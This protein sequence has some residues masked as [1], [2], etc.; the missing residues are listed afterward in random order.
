[1]MSRKTVMITL[2]IISTSFFAMGCF[3]SGDKSG[4]GFTQSGTQEAIVANTTI[5]GYLTDFEVAA[6]PKQTVSKAAATSGRRITIVADNK[7]YILATDTNGFFKADIE[8]SNSKTLIFKMQKSDASYIASE[9][10]VEKGNIYYLNVVLE[11]SGLKLTKETIAVFQKAM[12]SDPLK[13]L[14]GQVI[15]E[16]QKNK[17]YLSKISGRF[18]SARTPLTPASISSQS[19][20]VSTT[21]QPSAPISGAIVSLNGS[22]ST[23]TDENGYFSFTGQFAAGSYAV[24][25][26]KSGY[27]NKSLNINV[28]EK[29]YGLGSLDFLLQ[30]A[31]IFNSISLD[32]TSDIIVSGGSYELSK[33]KIY[34]NYLDGTSAEVSASW[35]ADHGTIFE[36]SYRSTINEKGTVTLTASYTEANTTRTAIFILSINT[37]LDSLYLSKNSDT[38]EV[39]NK[40]D[41]AAI[42]TIAVYSDKST[43]EVITAAWSASSGSISGLFYTP[44]D[45]FLGILNI[46]AEYTEGGISKKAVFKLTMVPKGGETPTAMAISTVQPATGTFGTQVN[47]TGKNFGDSQGTNV[48]KFNGV[49]TSNDDI[50]AWSNESIIAKVPSG[51]SSGYITISSNSSS[52]TAI[53]FEVIGITSIT[54]SIISVG[55]R[56]IINGTGFGPTPTGA[57]ISMGEITVNQILKWSN[58]KIEVI[59]PAGVKSGSLIITREIPTNPVLY[60]VSQIASA[61]PA[62]GPP[63]TTVALYGTG[64]GDAQGNSTITFNGT[65]AVDIISWTN[66]A[67]AL[68]VP[69]D[70]SSGNLSLNFN[71]VSGNNYLYF[72]VTKITSISPDFG[73]SGTDIEI[74]GTGFG[75]DRGLNDISFNGI[76]AT[77]IVS[78]TNG[79]IKV[80]TPAQ[81]LSGGVNVIIGQI[82]SNGINFNASSISSISPTSGTMGTS[83][84]INGFGFGAEKGS[85]TVS[86]NDVVSTNVT[87]WSS[88]KIV[89]TVPPLAASGNIKLSIGGVSMDGPAFNVGA[90]INSLSDTFLTTGS[91]LTVTGMNFGASRGTGVIK[92]NGIDAPSANI[93]SWSDD[94]IICRVPVGTTP[95]KVTVVANGTESNGINLDILNITSISP[96]GGTVGTTVTITGLGFGELQGESGFSFNSI[97]ATNIVSWTDT[98]AVIIV[99]A[100]AN[101]GNLTANVNGKTSNS[102]NFTITLINKLSVNYG[103]PGTIVEIDGTG[104]GPFPVPNT[105]KF[106]TITA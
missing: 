33:I 72:D 27:S 84:T 51:S 91:T 101:T 95:G 49:V 65:E 11:S 66:G 89:A 48:L 70:A 96:A 20:I 59:C 68:K 88:N 81:T 16:K 55:E 21:E 67:I 44:P 13:I 98:Q 57:A 52:M 74:N 2:L 62:F 31:S 40:Y 7:E 28:S 104:F 83:V 103:P 56:L 24:T 76:K 34:A 82:P 30:T 46:D 50:I 97:A 106:N 3:S 22:I 61:V 19:A 80:R 26:R 37:K 47:I 71:G 10:F 102:M 63:G 18:V 1:M 35:T 8:L 87:L 58:T 41:L 93:V 99:P 79:K 100:G 12:Q 29:D 5:A 92:F 23:T 54:P 17:Q 9:F 45:N 73:P 39:S 64:F 78:W 4:G 86:F 69:S 36:N 38:M 105:V 32:K 85:S 94:T 77:E 14:I 53:F 75:N 6:A 15:T 25:A 60:D 43:A 42:K 90:V